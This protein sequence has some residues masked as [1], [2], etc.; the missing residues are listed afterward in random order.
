MKKI[1]VLTLLV[2]TILGVTSCK[3]NSNIVP[4]NDIKQTYY[5]DDELERSLWHVKRD[6]L[7]KAWGNPD[8]RIEHE[9]EDIWILNE[10]QVLVVSYNRNNELNDLD[11]ED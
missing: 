1:I 3:N 5:N 7:I 8:R 10:R 4:L 2:L 9:N 6:D 11:I